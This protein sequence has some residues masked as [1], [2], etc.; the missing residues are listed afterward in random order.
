MCCVEPRRDWGGFIAWTWN[1]DLRCVDICNFTIMDN[2]KFIIPFSLNLGCFGILHGESERVR[3][4]ESLKCKL[5]LFSLLPRTDVGFTFILSHPLT[6]MHEFWSPRL[7]LNIGYLRVGK[8]MY[9]V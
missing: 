7:N 4:R 8:V 2:F 3:E 1:C 5:V 6:L 9:H